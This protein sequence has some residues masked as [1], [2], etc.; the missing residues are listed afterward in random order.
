MPN[1]AFYAVPASC[2]VITLL[3]R[4]AHLRLFSVISRSCLGGFWSRAYFGH[5]NAIKIGLEAAG[6]IAEIHVLSGSTPIQVPF[7]GAYQSNKT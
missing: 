7:L 5:R 3:S 2:M 4:A 6:L 1:P